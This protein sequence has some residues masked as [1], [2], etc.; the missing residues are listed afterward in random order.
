MATLDSWSLK[1]GA[2]YLKGALD[3]NLEAAGYV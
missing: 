1:E 3:W 2:R